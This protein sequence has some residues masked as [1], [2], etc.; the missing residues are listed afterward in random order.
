[1]AEERIIVSSKDLNNNSVKKITK[2]KNNSYKHFL[3][4]P[5][6]DL[7]QWMDQKFVSFVAPVSAV[8]LLAH[9]PKPQY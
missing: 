2:Q 7:K 1:M 8:D 6:I 5:H 3:I 9:V 4:F